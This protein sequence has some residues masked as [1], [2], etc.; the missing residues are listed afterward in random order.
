[1]LPTMPYRSVHIFERELGFEYNDLM[2]LWED[3]HA[4]A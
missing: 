1:M 2:M 4:E 3:F